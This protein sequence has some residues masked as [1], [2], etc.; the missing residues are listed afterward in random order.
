M[1]LII[2]FWF[3]WFRFCRI[4]DERVLEKVNSGKNRGQKIKN[5]YMIMGREI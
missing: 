4:Q 1:K 5:N 3:V 2:S